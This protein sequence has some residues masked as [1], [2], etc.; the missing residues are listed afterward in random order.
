MTDHCQDSILRVAL[1][2]T[3][4]FRH[5]LVVPEAA[6]LKQGLMLAPASSLLQKGCTQTQHVLKSQEKEMTAHLFNLSCTH[7][8]SAGAASIC[9]TWQ[10]LNP[11]P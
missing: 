9:C 3:T 11:A 8:A 1:L 7:S 10:R 6:E 5:Y 2:Q 4:G